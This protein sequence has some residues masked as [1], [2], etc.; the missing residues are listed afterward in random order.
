MVEM[1]VALDLKLFLQLF[2]IVRFLTHRISEHNFHFSAN[3]THPCDPNDDEFLCH[4]SE[5][6]SSLLLCDGKFCFFLNL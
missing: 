3:K 5:C 6:I 1:S 4:N 2:V